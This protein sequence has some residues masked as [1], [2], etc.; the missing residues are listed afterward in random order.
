[1]HPITLDTFSKVPGVKSTYLTN[2]GEVLVLLENGRVI[3]DVLYQ[4][5]HRD[6]DLQ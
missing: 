3:I 6:F 5:V 2:V 1:M 4:D